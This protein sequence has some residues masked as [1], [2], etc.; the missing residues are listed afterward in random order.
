[1]VED[2]RRNLDKVTGELLE[3]FLL[4]DRNRALHF[5]TGLYAIYSFQKNIENTKKTNLYAIHDEE[6]LHELLA[7]IGISPADFEKVPA[8]IKAFEE[9]N[10]SAYAAIKELPQML[11]EAINKVNEKQRVLYEIP[12]AGMIAVSLN[13]VPCESKNALIA[14]QAGER[15]LQVAERLSLPALPNHKKESRNDIL[16]DRL[17]DIS[18]NTR[19]ARPYIDM[20][21]HEPKYLLAAKATNHIADIMEGFLMLSPEIFSEDYM[22]KASDCL[23]SIAFYTFER[24]AEIL[25]ENGDIY[26]NSQMELLLKSFDF[27]RMERSEAISTLR[28]SLSSLN[29]DM[30][31]SKSLSYKESYDADLLIEKRFDQAE[32]W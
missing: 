2:I 7:N 18:S 24:C 17:Y 28:S 26:A 14:G 25:K 32:R 23:K 13:L 16:S 8:A 12:A 31:K 5:Q 21:Q 10:I 29:H 4:F 1:M 20:H 27:D 22:K 30:E 11:Q 3:S 9:G 6:K 15:T 19:L